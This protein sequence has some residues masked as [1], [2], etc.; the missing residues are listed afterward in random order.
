[1]KVIKVIYKATRPNDEG[2]WLVWAMVYINGSTRYCTLIYDTFEEANAIQVGQI[3]DGDR[4]R[5]S[6]RNLNTHNK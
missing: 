5:F 1:M 3:L 6:F 2:Y 4:T